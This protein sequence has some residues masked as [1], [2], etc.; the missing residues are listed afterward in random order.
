[1]MQG[2]MVNFQKVNLPQRQR[3][4]CGH[5]IF[6][7]TFSQKQLLL[8]EHFFQHHFPNVK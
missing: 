1:M 3:E 8:Q 4:H 2:E 7:L 6:R 5:F